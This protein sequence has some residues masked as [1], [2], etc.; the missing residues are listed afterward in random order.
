MADSTNTT[1]AALDRFTEAM[2]QR[3]QQMKAS[4]WKQGWI[5]SDSA[6][7]ALP[8]NVSG[9]NYSGSN[10]F[11]LQLDTAMNGYKMPVYM[12]YMQA[13]NYGA[14]VNKGEKSIPVFYWDVMMRDADGKR[15]SKEDFRKMSEAEKKQVETIPFLKTFSVFNVQQTTFAQ[16]QPKLYEKLV[17]DFK[18][19]DIRDTEGMFTSK[20]LD[21]MLERQ[22]WLCPVQH[23][24]IAPSAF[25]SPLEDRIVV[26]A[27]RQFKISNTPEEIYKDGMEWYSSFLHEATH[28]VHDSPKRNG[29]TLGGKFGDPQYAKSELVAELSAAMVGNAMGFD[30]RILNNN[31][32]Y[33]DAWIGV[34]KKEPKFIVSVMADVNKASTVILEEIDK[35][36]IA[37]GE[38]PLLEKNRSNQE[39]KEEQVKFDNAAIVKKNN[40]EY[41]VRASY[42]GE[43]LGMREIPKATGRLYASLRD[44]EQKNRILHNMLM[45]YYG[46]D[47]K[48]MATQ[49]VSKSLKI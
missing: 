24:K 41:A 42:Q 9:R 13:V 8:Q 45:K 19:P 32:A 49:K 43:E 44:P 37:L 22:E 39:V 17:N 21:R 11:F 26:P 1:Q 34:L 6:V 33:L 20:A 7:G 16:E 15:V 40:G 29:G 10:S 14:H 2:I 25:Y 46:D 47:I 23:D 48:Q 35:Q 3:M 4:D 28:S 5:G 12:T 18:T 31:A 36:K 38:R 27:K 30:K